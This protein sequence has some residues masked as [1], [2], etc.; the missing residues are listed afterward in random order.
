M[1][2]ESM[3]GIRSASIGVW[4][5][6]GSVHEAPA[7]MGVSHL[8]EH[9][10]FKGTR[11]RTARDLAL[12]LERVGGSLDAYTTREHTSYQARVLDADIDL[13]LDVLADVVTAP[14][15]RESDLE[16]EREVVL[17]EIATVEDT[18]DDLVFDLHA[19]LMWG[20]HPYGYSILGTTQTVSELTVADLRRV[21]AARYVPDNMVI[22]AAGNVD[23][24]SFVDRVKAEFC[25]EAAADRGGGLPSGD[26]ARH[27]LVSGNGNGAGHAMLPEPV[28][29]RSCVD[30]R[31]AQTHLVWGRPTFGQGDPRRFG[32]VLLSNAFGG[33][34]SSR[35]F[36]RVREEMGLAY[37]VFSF[38]SFYADAGVSG[39]YVGTRPES[40]DRAEA[41]IEDELRRLA[42]DGI[43][44]DELDDVKGQ[45]KGQ[46]VLSL[47][48]SSARLHRLAGTEL[49]GEP[50]R[51]MDEITALVEAVTLD[52]VGGLA[53]QYFAPGT[54]ALLRLG[55][56]N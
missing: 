4:V 40:A 54:Q 11:R 1:L 10:V 32:L 16:M 38:Q 35:L 30:R 33:G 24:D 7:E 52:E 20:D 17:E 36:Q 39:V 18:P 26:A 2:T 48:S 14:L 22:A 56:G 3:P 50:F 53:A 51:S 8:L 42:E 41:V 43:T 23:H 45:V 47:E 6:A 34:M 15:L 55:P 31:T 13:A 46:I 37:S 29:C 49:Y 27:G 28:P 21:H 44:S 5:R 12:V 9:M 25:R 19:G